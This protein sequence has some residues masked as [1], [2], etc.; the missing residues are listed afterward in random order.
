MGLCCLPLDAAV[1]TLG[2]LSLEDLMNISVTSVSKKTTSIEDSP[3]AITVINS[4]EILRLGIT[5]LP[6]ALRL[7]PG[8][9]VARIDASHWAISSRGFNRDFANKL[10]VLIDGRSVYTPAYGGVNWR[11][12]N[13]M[14]EDLD[15]IEVIRGPG[16]ALWGANAVNGVINLISKSSQETQGLL[17]TSSFGSLEQ[18]FAAIRYGGKIRSNLHYRAYLQGF[19]RTSFSTLGGADAGDDWDAIR[20]GF[21]ADWQASATDLITV[22]GDCYHIGSSNRV[23]I[24]TLV[25]PFLTN[26]SINNTNLGSNLL[27]RWTRTISETSHFTIQGYFDHFRA[28]VNT[29]HES[30]RTSD[31]QLEHRFSVGDRNDIIWGIGYRYTTDEYND[32]ELIR[33]NITNDNFQ[34]FN[35]FVQDEIAL[36]P[37]RLWLTLGSKLERNDYTD[38]EL[39]PGARLLW[40]P[41]KNQTVW[42][43]ASHAVSTPSRFYRDGQ[44]T[45]SIHQPPGGG[46]PVRTA[47][48]G[49]HNVGSESL[50]AFELGYRLEATPELSFDLAAF[51]NKYDDVAGFTAQAPR[52]QTTPVP[53]ILIPADFENNISG[54]TFGTELTIGWMP[55]DNWKLVA[56]Y[57]F[58]DMRMSNPTIAAPN[59]QQQVGLRAYLTLPWNL[60][61][62]GAI[63]YVDSISP[64]TLNRTPIDIP[65]YLRADLGIVWKATP[66][67]EI[68]LWG[69]NLLDPDHP[70]FTSQTGSNIT[71]VPRSIMGKLTW[72]F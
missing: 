61:L 52:P 17:V 36:V 11:A 31:L 44:L 60:E 9:E 5:S 30:R 72:R 65:S 49:N 66:S 14:L 27:G 71:E 21:R 40:K 43:S 62:N 7:V 10:L 67:L 69:H 41:A 48:I 24:P 54:E 55:T 58:I 3:A 23:N 34:L 46:V 50:N 29:N 68:G 33:W 35:L 12:Q 63:Q 8:L 15:R 37:H 56:S 16:A 18:P 57:S 42:A 19:D 20:G 2:D 64:L 6:E 38:W 32:T 53:H 4:D 51:Y 26:E 39:Q 28:E 13:M 45:L 59:P 70:E 1:T 47:V 22:Q 25:P